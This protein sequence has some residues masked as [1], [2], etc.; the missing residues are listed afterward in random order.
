MKTVM[1]YNGEG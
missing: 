1:D